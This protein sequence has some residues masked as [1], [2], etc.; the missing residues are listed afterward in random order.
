M[1]ININTEHINVAKQVTSI[2]PA[3]LGTNKSISAELE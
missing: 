2:F 3:L 1:E